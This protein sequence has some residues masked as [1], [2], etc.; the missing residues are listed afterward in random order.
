MG[1]IFTGGKRVGHR[2]WRRY[3]KHQFHMGNSSSR[4]KKHMWHPWRRL[5]HRFDRKS[6]NL[7]RPSSP[8]GG[9]WLRR[10]FANILILVPGKPEWLV[11]RTL[12]KI[13]WYDKPFRY[14]TERDVTD[15]QTDGWT[16]LLY[17][18]R[19][20]A[21]LIVALFSG[22]LR[23][24]VQKCPSSY[25]FNIILAHLCKVSRRT[26]NVGRVRVWYEKS[27]FSTDTSLHRLFSATRPSGVNNRVPSNRDKLVTS[28]VA[29]SGGVCWS[30]ETDDEAPRSESCLW[31]K[32]STL[33]RR[34]QNIIWLYALALTYSRNDLK[35]FCLIVRTDLLLFFLYGAPRRFVEWRLTNLPLYLYCI[36]KSEA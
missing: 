12:K 28:L 21:L 27:V 10:I 8:V 24:Q 25:F 11:Y 17:Q 29:S 20:S 7:Y 6:R 9:G 33:L 2:R 36:C 30:Q 16:E 15:R 34:Q 26:Y 19:T 3:H 31:R 5:L 13:S 1:W 14:N 18:H 32:V 35:L 23:D 4:R 22:C